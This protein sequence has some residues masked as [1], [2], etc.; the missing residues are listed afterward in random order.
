MLKLYYNSKTEM[1]TEWKLDTKE[2]LNR[3]L[4]PLRT[5]S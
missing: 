3:S 5:R 4:N 2:C 1:Y